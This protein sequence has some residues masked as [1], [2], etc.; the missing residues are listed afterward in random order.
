M[1]LN[2]GLNVF[3]FIDFLWGNVDG[4]IGYKFMVG[5]ISGG[6]DIF[7][8]M[9]VGNV[10]IYDFGNFLYSMIIYVIIMFYNGNGDV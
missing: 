7:N 2:G 1:L 8:S 5:I 9:D 6:I 10:M 3:I 4:V